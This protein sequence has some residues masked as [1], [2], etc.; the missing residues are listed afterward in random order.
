[1]E[2]YINSCETIG[3]HVKWVRDGKEL[4]GKAKSIQ[5]DG[6]LILTT[7]NETLTVHSGEIIRQAEERK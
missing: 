2:D 1:M 3:N 5:P 6:S 4:Y 7:E